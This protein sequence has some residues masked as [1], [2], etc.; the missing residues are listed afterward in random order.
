M[1]S[2]VSWRYNLISKCV[3][4]ITKLLKNFKF[5]LGIIVLW[6]RVLRSPDWFDWYIELS[7]VQFQRK[8]SLAKSLT[9]STFEDP[10]LARHKVTSVSSWSTPRLWISCFK[11]LTGVI[12]NFFKW[13]KRMELNDNK[14]RITIFFSFEIRIQSGLKGM[15]HVVSLCHMMMSHVTHFFE[16]WDDDLGYRWQSGISRVSS[17][18]FCQIS[19]LFCQYDTLYHL[20]ARRKR[21]YSTSRD[22]THVINPNQ[23]L[24]IFE[25][26][27]KSFNQSTFR[28]N[29][30]IKRSPEDVDRRQKTYW[31]DRL[32][33]R[34][35]C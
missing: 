2:V 5:K 29:R 26:S 16:S 17:E 23:S 21:L 9:D 20:K 31:K 8:S 10:K 12:C 18:W 15:C 25:I 22:Q 11:S 3:L 14:Y 27:F 34:D 6:L 32:Q 13:N 7:K 35:A 4:Y 24:T 33:S 28:G 1:V 19:A 30:L